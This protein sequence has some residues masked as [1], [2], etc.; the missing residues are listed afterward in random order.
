MDVL[1]NAH[2]TEII[3][4]IIKPAI[5]QVI[6]DLEDADSI[7]LDAQVDKKAMRKEITFWKKTLEQIEE[8]R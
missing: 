2:C 1:A 4:H 3:E 7:T 6:E 5:N 8:V